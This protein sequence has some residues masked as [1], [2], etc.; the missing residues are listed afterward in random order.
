M[1][2]FYNVFLLVD[3]YKY[4]KIYLLDNVIYHYF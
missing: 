2:Y 3:L 4:I 1:T